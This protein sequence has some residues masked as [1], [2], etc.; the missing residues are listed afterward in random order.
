MVLLGLEFG[1]VI[2]PWRSVIV[3]C[4]IVFGVLTTGLFLLIEWKF[5]RYPIMPTRI[6]NSLSN[7]AAFGVC[8][9]HGFVFIAGTYYLPLYFQ[10][11]LGAPPLISGVYLLPLVLTL[12]LA[13]GAT[14]VFIKRT[15]KYLPPLW[16]GMVLLIIGSGLLIDLPLDKNWAK[17]IVYQMITGI[18]VG[19]NFQSPILAIQS[20]I[21][22][23]DIATA[24]A[25]A[26][27][28]FS[29]IRNFATSISVVID[30]IV[31]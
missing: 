16:F 10:A 14:G 18:G 27:A 24:T 19:L 28:T 7:V 1:G 2:Y 3:I 20:K 6:F 13:S 22:K 29:F 8:F 15:G 23:Q 4:L 17:I 11:V 30:G 31:F 25:A 26:T 9:C 12:S 5:A 21:A